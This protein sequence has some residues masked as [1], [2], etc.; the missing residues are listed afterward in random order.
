MVA[1]N[2]SAP[3][4]P[5]HRAPRNRLL[6]SLSADDWAGVEPLLERVHLTVSQVLE[7]SSEASPWL[8]FPESAVIAMVTT[9]ADGRRVEVGTVGNEGMCGMSAWLEAEHDGNQS[10]CQIAGATLRGRA[11]D[12]IAVSARR[13][14]IHRLL[15]RYASAY[16]GLVEQGTACNRIHPLERRCARWLLMTCDRLPSAHLLL[17]PEMIATMLGVPHEGAAIAIQALRGHGLIRASRDRIDI[18]DRPGLERMSCECY[19]VVRNQ[20]ARIA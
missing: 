5:G 13:P 19:E 8:H 15:S 9:F 17:T 1:P 6:E 2:G 4:W 16:L 7:P 3:E 18:M 10:L 20:F 12:I 14:S 11:V